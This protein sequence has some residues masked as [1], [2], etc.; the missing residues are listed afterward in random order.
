LSVKLDKNS[1]AVYPEIASIILLLSVKLDKNSV[2]VFPVIA[3]EAL[4]FNPV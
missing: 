3:A 2:A 4:S 1:V